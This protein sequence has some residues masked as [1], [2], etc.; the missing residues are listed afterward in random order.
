MKVYSFTFYL[1]GN[2]HD[3]EELSNRIYEAGGDDTAISTR[4]EVFRIDYDREAESL[5]SAISSAIGKL[6]S[7]GYEVERLEMDDEELGELIQ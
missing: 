3:L 6:R 5:E 7:C 4:D 1:N 2:D